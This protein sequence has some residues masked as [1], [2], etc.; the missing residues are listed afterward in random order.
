MQKKHSAVSGRDEPPARPPSSQQ[1]AVSGRV[2]PPARPPSSQQSAVSGRDDPPGR[3]PSSQQSAVSQ[4]R[5]RQAQ[6]GAVRQ[7]TSHLWERDS[8]RARP[9]HA[10]PTSLRPLGQDRRHTQIV[11]R[12][13]QRYR[14]PQAETP[15]AR[16]DLPDPRPQL[17][18][19]HRR[20]HPPSRRIL[21]QLRTPN[22]ER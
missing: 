2:E 13:R 6:A 3:P 22:P 8:A 17:R 7:K 18:H 9:A 19:P 15:P 4:S 10:R 16:G 21:R 20:I 12:R 11:D 5:H 14:Q 1:S